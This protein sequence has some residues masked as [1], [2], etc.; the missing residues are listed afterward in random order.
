MKKILSGL[1]VLAG[2]FM[3][4]I[5]P[6]YA[7]SIYYA[8]PL[9]QHSS[10]SSLQTIFSVTQL[11]DFSRGDFASTNATVEIRL[12]NNVVA[13]STNNWSSATIASGSLWGTIKRQFA[14]NGSMTTTTQNFMADTGIGADGGSTKWATSSGWASTST[15][16]LGY[17]VIEISSTTSTPSSNDFNIGAWMYGTSPRAG[18]P[19]TVGGPNTTF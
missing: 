11:P 9:W 1:L 17:A 14:T 16:D 8:V 6:S 3:F 18:F 4:S 15:S 5:A 13:G 19:L 12:Y 7:G 10:G 2:V